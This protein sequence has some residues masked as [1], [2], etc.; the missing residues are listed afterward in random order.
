MSDPSAPV[1]P[2]ADPAMPPLPQKKRGISCMGIIAIFSGIFAVLLLIVGI[3]VW[4]AVSWIKN[5]PEA[6]MSI[7]DKVKLEPGEEEDANRI[8]HEIDDVSKKKGNLID[9]STTLNVLN[10]IVQFIIEEEAKK[11]P[12]K[13]DNA[14]AARFALKGDGYNAKVVMPAR[15]ADTGAVI[16]GM[17]LNIDVD[18]DAEIVDGKFTKLE[19]HRFALGNKEAPLAARVFLYFGAKG[20]R[21]GKVDDDKQKDFQ[22][23]MKAIRLLKREGERIHLIVDGKQAAETK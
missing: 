13:P 22:D 10:G 20:M 2:S 11:S 17:F 12:Q 5:A 3:L 6:T 14:I 1:P 9:E 16:P 8:I 18:F 23:G 21:E 19:V 7:T 4:Q 15:D